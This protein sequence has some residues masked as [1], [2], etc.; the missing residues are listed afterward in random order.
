MTNQK[1]KK[2]PSVERDKI[3]KEKVAKLSSDLFLYGK[4]R[5]RMGVRPF[6]LLCMIAQTLSSEKEVS[7][8]QLFQ[9]EY[10]YS[11]T[12]VFEYLGLTSTNQR[13][14]LLIEDM[15]ELMSTVV[16]YKTVSKRGTIRWRGINFL[17]FCDIDE[18][19]GRLVVQVNE[20]AKEYLIGMKR[21]SALQPKYYLKLS[22]EYQNWFYVFLK[23]EAGVQPSIT[24]EIDTLKEMLC[25]DNL[26]YYDPRQTK[27]AN[28]NFFGKVLGIKKPKGWKYNP[29]G[30]NDPWDYI[31]DKETNEITGTIGTITKETDINVSA[32]PVKEGR[33][34]TKVRFELS[35]K[36]A[37]LSKVEKDLLHKKA[38]QYDIQDMGKPN[39]RGRSK[40]KG[41][42]SMADIFGSVPVVGEHQNPMAYPE[43]MPAAKTTISAKT[44]EETARSMGVPPEQLA[45]KLGYKRREDG[46]WEK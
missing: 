1:R 27:N 6:R 21:W 12:K 42:Q 34:Y 2:L 31:T 29:T 32:Y 17:A 41:P 14:N 3:S 22:T 37:T 9:T 13:Y 11:P 40:A 43:A 28:E 25:I 10:T 35:R 24:V 16:E 45:A 44:V 7:G 15:K 46:N 36:A 4:T 23:K 30:K 33:S 5:W 38:T 39:R 19:T 20:R 18:D 26:K 8:E